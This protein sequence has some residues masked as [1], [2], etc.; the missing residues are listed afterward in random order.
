MVSMRE[1]LRMSRRQL[2]DIALTYGLIIPAGCSDV[3]RAHHVII[4]LSLM[5]RLDTR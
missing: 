2:D 1:V 3:T 4:G 5:F